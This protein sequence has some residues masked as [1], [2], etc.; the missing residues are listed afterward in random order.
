MLFQGGALL[1]ALTIHDNVALPI[2]ELAPGVPRGVVDEMV[3]MKLSLVGLSH[4]AEL[5]PPSLSGGMKK[6]AALARAMALDPAVLFC[7]EPS[8]GLDPVTAAQLDEL[9][10]SLRDRFGMA[11][12]IVTH[13]LP[14]IEAIADH[15]TMLSRGQV[16][17]SGTLAQVRACAHPEVRAFFDRSAEHA[18]QRAPSLWSTLGQ[19]TP[20]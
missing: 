19:E 16:L 15:A 20:T 12:V 7:D 3:R 1:N 8:A 5:T 4:A 10:L 18:V 17:V 9:I 13:E 6:R 11:V 2:R 14:S